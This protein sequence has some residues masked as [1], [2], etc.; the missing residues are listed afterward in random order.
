MTSL[1]CGIQKE[2]IQNELTYKTERDSQTQKTHLQLL[3]ERDSQ[4]LWEGQ[5]HTAIFEMD[6]QQRPNVQHMELCSTLCASQDESGI[7]W[8]MDACV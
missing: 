7:W 3:E 1:T 4:G 2:M 5:V 6:N 8:R